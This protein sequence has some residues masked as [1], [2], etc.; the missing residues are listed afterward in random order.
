[1]TVS[2]VP[3]T[4]TVRTIAQGPS[5]MCRVTMIANAAEPAVGGAR[6]RHGMMAPVRFWPMVACTAMAAASTNCTT[7]SGLP[8]A[9]KSVP[10]VPPACAASS[11][12]AEFVGTVGE[13]GNAT[14]VIALYNISDRSCGVS[15][16]PTLILENA[17]RVAA[18]VRY[19]YRYQAPYN[20]PGVSRPS[21]IVLSPGRKAYFEFNYFGNQLAP[22]PAGQRCLTISIVVVP[23][24]RHASPQMIDVPYRAIHVCGGASPPPV[25][26][27]PLLATDPMR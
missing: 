10:G 3:L 6:A 8:P 21:R 23:V 17:H 11:L 9:R 16:Y 19:L 12:K 14:T 26:V 5:S 2:V 27:S 4:T 15:G 1:V 7:S 25:V 24:P 18:P 20:Y 13:S 22:P